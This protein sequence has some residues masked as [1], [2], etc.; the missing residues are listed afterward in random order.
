MA[1]KHENTEIQ[2]TEAQETFHID[3][4]VKAK[5]K[6]AMAKDAEKAPK[7]KAPAEPSLA[8]RLAYDLDMDKSKVRR[9]MRKFKDEADK[10]AAENPEEKPFGL[11][12]GIFDDYAEGKLTKVHVRTAGS[13]NK[14]RM[15]RAARCLHL[16]EGFSK[17]DIIGF[18]QEADLETKGVFGRKKA[19]EAEEEVVEEDAE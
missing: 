15:L 1:K 8:Q 2:E 4:D 6:A 13:K 10:R 9:L 18:I 19:E 7:R 3:D 12:V 16:D 14:S 17:E 5:I 11:W